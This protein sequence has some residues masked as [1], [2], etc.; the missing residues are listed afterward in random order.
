MVPVKNISFTA[1]L[2]LL[3]VLCLW[4]GVLLFFPQMTP[5]NPLSTQ[6]KS[7]LLHNGTE[8]A[9]SGKLNKEY[10]SGIYRCKQCDYQ[11]FSSQAKFD[12]E[13]G[14]PSFDDAL[15]G[16]IDTS[17]DGNR[18]EVHCARC[19]GHLGH[20]FKDE[21]FTPKNS[22][23]CINSL[24]LNFSADTSLQKAYFAGGCFWGVEFYLQKVP[25]VLSVTSGFMGG[26]TPDPTYE[27]VS[28]GTTDYVE[29]VEVVYDTTKVNYPPLAKQF[30]EIHN[31]YQ[32]DG[33]G[34]DKGPQY[35]SKVFVSTPREKEIIDSLIELLEGRRVGV[36]THIEPATQFY[37]AR[38]EHQDYYEKNGGT[39]YC[40]GVTRRFK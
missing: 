40:H 39:P 15:E 10:R 18:T 25:G 22:R 19:K 6:E 2:T 5:Y 35:L 9:Y 11:L 21:G 29:C 7:I 20:L 32:D 30:F 28:S 13:S 14:W 38:E 4:A 23:Y 1:L 12:S 17:T 33:Q 36:A 3:I 8:P 27:I 26:T 34:S 37:P 24:S 31:P 16:H